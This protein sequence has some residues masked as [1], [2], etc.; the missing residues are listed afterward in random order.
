MNAPFR[1]ILRRLAD[2]A[3]EHGRDLQIALRL[4][5]PNHELWQAWP[6]RPVELARLLARLLDEVRERVDRH[7]ARRREAN[8]YVAGWRDRGEVAPWVERKLVVDDRVHP[9][10]GAERE[11]ERVV[12]FGGNEGCDACDPIAARTI[13]DHDRLTPPS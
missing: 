7:R 4:K 11:Q 2:I 10:R 5:G 8:Q 1:E 9:H 13:L 6:R 3:I 12:V